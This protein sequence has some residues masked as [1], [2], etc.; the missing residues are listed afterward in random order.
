MCELLW[1]AGV[2]GF[3]N[4]YRWLTL[5]FVNFIYFNVGV[6]HIF[7]LNRVYFSCLNLGQLHIYNALVKSSRISSFSGPHFPEFQSKS[8]SLI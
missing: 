6:Q 7:S 2:K 8:P 3:E 5:H 4:L 1:Q